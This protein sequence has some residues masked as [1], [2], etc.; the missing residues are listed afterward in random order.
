MRTSRNWQQM[1]VNSAFRQWRETA[2][3]TVRQREMLAR[4]FRRVKAITLPDLFRAWKIIAVGEKLERTV[5]KKVS[6]EKELKMLEEKLRDS[7]KNEGDLMVDMVRME[8]DTKA[9]RA[10]LKTLQEAI[11]A[12]RI[13]ETRAVISSVGENLMTLGNVG[14]KNIE[15]ILSEAASSPDPQILAGIYY[16]ENDEKEEAK[17]KK[18]GTLKEISSTSKKGSM[19]PKYSE[20]QVQIALN[21]IVKLSPDR[22]LL[23]WV[24]YRTRLGVPL[25]KASRKVENFGEDLRDGIIY[26]NIMNRLSK[27]RNRANIQNEIDP[28]RRIDIVLAQA[29]RLD[30]PASGFITTGHVL[31]CDETLNVAFIGRLFNTHGRLEKTSESEDIKNYVD[32]VRGGGV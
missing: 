12:Q 21:E 16:V 17:K 1:L 13:P 19:P 5:K 22:L 6:K 11:A 23:R 31:G 32:Q 3:N 28:Q 24:K 10:R 30:P 8:K 25:G 26:G 29:S 14:F 27:R 15:S 20:N 2:K 4:Y 9:L 18:N 7:K